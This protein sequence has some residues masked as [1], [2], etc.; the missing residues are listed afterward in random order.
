MTTPNHSGSASRRAALLALPL[1][2]ALC[3]GAWAQGQDSVTAPMGPQLNEHPPP[4]LS[5]I[6]VTSVPS[7]KGQ[8]SRPGTEPPKVVQANALDLP[9]MVPLK[10]PARLECNEIA[11]RNAR[12]RC[13]TRKTRP[14]PPVGVPR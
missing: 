10:A 7:G 9:G 6:S 11:D 8:P 12:R 3:G 2:P 14:A 5:T 1:L 4:L 13:A